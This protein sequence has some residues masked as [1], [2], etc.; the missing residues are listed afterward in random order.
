MTK[1]L[2]TNNNK[3]INKSI[4]ILRRYGSLY[5]TIGTNVIKVKTWRPERSCHEVDKL[6]GFVYIAILQ[7]VKIFMMGTI[8]W[9][10]CIIILIL[11]L[12]SIPNWQGKE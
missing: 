7:N 2:V 8:K 6:C 12:V 10:I 5:K 9:L 11:I 3:I 1:L 4:K